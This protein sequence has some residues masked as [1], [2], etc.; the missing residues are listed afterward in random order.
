MGQRQFPLRNV[1]YMR[2]NSIVRNC[3]LLFSIPCS[4]GSH[5]GVRPKRCKALRAT[6]MW[7]GFKGRRGLKI[8]KLCSEGGATGNYWINKDQRE[9]SHI[10][11]SRMIAKRYLP[12]SIV[13][14]VITPCP[15]A[16]QQYRTNF[17]LGVVSLK[18]STSFG[19]ATLST[20]KQPRTPK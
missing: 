17:V 6:N 1:C 15:F 16:I 5:W 7:K 18:F 19:C 12:I 20:S 4:L 14:I 10:M 13:R 8:K 11:L 9:T 2:D 3:S